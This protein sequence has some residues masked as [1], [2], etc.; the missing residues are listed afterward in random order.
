[1]STLKIRKATT[2]DAMFIARTV[3]AAIEILDFDAVIPADML[4]DVEFLAE[5]AKD[6]TRLYNFSQCLVAED[7]G[8]PVGCIIAYDGNEYA[9]LRRKSFEILFQERGLDLRANPMETQTGEF[10]LDSMA[11]RKAYRGQGIGHELMLAAMEK[12]RTCGAKKYT[13]LVDSQFANLR[14]YYMQLGFT[15]SEYM[16]AFGA[17]YEKLEKLID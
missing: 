12:G 17:E 6:E 9:D 1:M 15:H 16:N 4:K 2:D 3:F 14:N 11:I 13:L 7:D 5:S 8:E 10:Y